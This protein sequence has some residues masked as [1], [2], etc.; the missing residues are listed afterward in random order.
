MK[1][2]VK[3]KPGF[4]L[5]RKSELK[6]HANALRRALRD[7]DLVMKEPSTNERGK[8]IAAVMNRIDHN[9]QFFERFQLGID[10]NKLDYTR[11]LK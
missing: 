4:I 7:M 2:T 11:D 10:L 1:D 3:L 9:R 6:A 8:K 5:L